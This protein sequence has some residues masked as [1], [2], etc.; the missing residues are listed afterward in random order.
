M[1]WGRCGRV[2]QTYKDKSTAAL[3]CVHVFIKV[4]ETSRQ[5]GVPSNAGWAGDEHILAQACHGCVELSIIWCNT[6][7]WCGV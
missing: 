2:T 6:Q 3:S 7:R 1:K 5:S 4:R